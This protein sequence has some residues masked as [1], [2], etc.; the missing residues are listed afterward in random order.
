MDW[1]DVLA[2][3][4]ILILFIGIGYLIGWGL[5]LILQRD[6]GLAERLIVGLAIVLI[7]ALLQ[8]PRNG[9]K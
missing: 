9:V 6:W 4:I 8:P 1:G 5:D 3:L 2:I 7:A